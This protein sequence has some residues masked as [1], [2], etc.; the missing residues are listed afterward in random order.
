MAKTN[1]LFVLF[2]ERPYIKMK[3]NKYA[4]YMLKSMPYFETLCVMKFVSC[5]SFRDM[6]MVGLYSFTI[7]AK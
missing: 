2:T 7:T 1:T 4:L 3:Y 5:M 6:D